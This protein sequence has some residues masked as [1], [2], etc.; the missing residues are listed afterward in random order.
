MRQLPRCWRR[1]PGR[2]CPSTTS[3]AD[4]GGGGGRGRGLLCAAHPASTGGHTGACAAALG[5]LVAG[6]CAFCRHRLLGWAPANWASVHLHAGPLAAAAAGVLLGADARGHVSCP[7]LLPPTVAQ[8]AATVASRTNTTP[9]LPAQL[10]IATRQ[11]AQSL[12]MERP[13]A[14]AL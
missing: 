8:P 7:A 14:L 1:Q 9:S 12:L 3:A 11:S 6:V 10:L 13:L 2:L 4:S 5:L